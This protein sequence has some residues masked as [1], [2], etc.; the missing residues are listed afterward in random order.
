MDKQ[1]GQRE[2]SL[3]VRV[4]AIAE[5]AFGD[6]ERLYLEMLGSPTKSA[7]NALHLYGFCKP[8]AL[9]FAAFSFRSSSKPAASMG[10]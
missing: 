3:L 10:T 6:W 7:S 8:P 4:W 9:F 1:S 5:A 2:S